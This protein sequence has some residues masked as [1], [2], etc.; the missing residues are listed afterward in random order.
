MQAQ[1]LYGRSGRKV[2]PGHC[3]LPVPGSPARARYLS[4]HPSVALS[5][6][7]RMNSSKML[8]QS[9]CRTMLEIVASNYFF[10]RCKKCLTLVCD[11][12]GTYARKTTHYGY[13]RCTFRSRYVFRLGRAALRPFARGAAGD[14][15]GK[16]VRS[17]GCGR[18]FLRG[19]ILWH[20]FGPANPD[21]A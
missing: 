19:K 9:R 11:L 16:S 13:A 3:G 5:V 20:S 17:R 15:G 2:R 1:T 21:G 4:S 8:N 12:M 18:M 10:D 7:N 6:Q 14:C